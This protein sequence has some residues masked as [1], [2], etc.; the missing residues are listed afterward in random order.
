[1]NN[2]LQ[3]V[4]F[5]MDGVIIES[6]MSH[7]LAI[8]EAMLPAEMSVSYQLYLDTCTGSDERFAMTRMADLSGIPY[9]EKLYQS[10]SRR[11][12]VSYARLVGEEAK[13]MPGAVELVESV[14]ADLPI[15]LATGSRACD[16]EAALNNLADGRLAGLFQTI[17]TA[18]E[19]ENSKPDPATYATAVDN[20][21]MDPSACF[22]IEDSPDGIK[23]ALGAGLRVIGV[24]VMHDEAKLYEAEKVLPTLAGVTLA[25]LKQWFAEPVG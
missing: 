21:G 20:L 19:V 18:D 17:V 3:A 14:A 8:K 5:D 7:Y 24:A 23:S 22:A 25:D 13:A 16:V 1:M 10:W 15:G 9:D 11:K 2:E 6:E 4:V 12:A